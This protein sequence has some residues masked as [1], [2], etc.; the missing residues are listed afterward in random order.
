M[1]EGQ[2]VR[3]FASSCIDTSDGFIPAIS[4][5]IE[6]NTLGFHLN[7]ELNQ[8]VDE[9]LYQKM[10]IAGIPPWILLAGPHGEFELLF[11]IPEGCVDQFLLAANE[12]SWIPISLGRAIDEPHLDFQLS[13]THQQYR[14]S[15][16]A[17]L[18]HTCEGNVNKYFREL[19]KINQ[20]WLQQTTLQ[21]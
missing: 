9:D 1:A 19:L 13:G 11:T 15:G 3:Q 7:E 21:S 14:P 6:I 16:I 10:D 5:I 8:I 4:N 18:Y 17:N 20:S 12:I 2:L